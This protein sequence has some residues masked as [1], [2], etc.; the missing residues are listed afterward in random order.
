M[1]QRQRKGIALPYAMILLLGLTAVASLAVDL[2]RVVLVKS[3]LRAAADAAALAGG[4]DLLS[5]VNI[6]RA[7]AIAIAK[8]NTANGAPVTL[9]SADIEFVKWDEE[10]RT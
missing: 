8:A 7:S 2:G 9:T 3:Q 10:T 6:A 4:Q 5:D 1:T